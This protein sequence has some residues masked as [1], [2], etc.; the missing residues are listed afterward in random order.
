MTGTIQSRKEGKEEKERKSAGP[1]L[2]LQATQRLTEVNSTST[3]IRFG[4]PW[5]WRSLGG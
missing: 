4:M 5:T 1:V 2:A 3:Q